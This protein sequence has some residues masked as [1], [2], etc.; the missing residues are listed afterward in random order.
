MSKK[1]SLFATLSIL[2]CACTSTQ[3]GVMD[4]L[5]D[6]DDGWL[7]ASNYLLEKQ[8]SFLPIPII[9]TE[10]A[11]DNGLGLAGVFFHK[12][13]ESEARAQDKFERPSLSAIAGAY[14]GNGSW[15]L[16]GG[17]KG[18]WRKDTVI[19]T[20]GGGYGSIN[21][22]YFSPAG[23]PFEFNTEGYFITQKM[24][25]RMADSN[26]L[27]GG[28]WEFTDLDVEFQLDQIIPG[29]ENPSFGFQNS[30]LGP[31]VEFESRD[32]TFTPSS[33]QHFRFEALVYDEAIGGDY[34]YIEYQGSYNT[35]TT[36]AQSWVIGTRLEADIIDGDAPFVARPF[37]DMRG[38]PA[39]R[40]QGNAVVE[41]ELETRWDFHPRVSAIGFIGVGRAAASTSDLGSTS[42]EVAGGIGIRYL[43]ARALGLRAG[44]DVAWGPED[45]YIYLTIGQAWN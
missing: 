33:G 36:F 45:T 7:D 4:R 1:N 32:S 44:L 20:G 11:V 35:F 2:L 40:Y 23:R 26:W 10:P 31:N 28:T 42:N 29:I 16:G 12:R 17:H 27:L 41:A 21:L 9:I 5:R 18:I 38:I 22:D 24:Q 3:A 15:M 6:P 25:F 39:M 30:G 13:P 43:M 37:I 14:T 8:G 34:D 19:Y